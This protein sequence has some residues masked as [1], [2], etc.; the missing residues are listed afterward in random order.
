MDYYIN[1]TRNLFQFIL[2]SSIKCRHI[3]SED[4][5]RENVWHMR[6]KEAKETIFRRRTC[7]GSK[8][9]NKPLDVGHLE[10]IMHSFKIY[11]N[12]SMRYDVNIFMLLLRL[13]GYEFI[14]DLSN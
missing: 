3:T 4:R 8:L 13:Q 2:K 6:M 12:P 5:G 14:V 10:I 7:V 11:S 1:K 9:F